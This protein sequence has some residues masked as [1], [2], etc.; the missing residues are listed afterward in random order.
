MAPATPSSSKPVHCTDLVDASESCWGGKK[1]PIPLT[2]GLR[3]RPSW[4][5]SSVQQKKCYWCTSPIR[6]LF[7]KL[8]PPPCAV[9]LVCILIHERHCLCWYRL[10]W[11]SLWISC[12]SDYGWMFVVSCVALVGFQL[13][14][15]GF[16]RKEW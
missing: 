11:C 3:P 8:P 4:H 1:K 15:T 13:S 16:G 10:F 9:L 14:L 5:A 7:L 6:F 12:V 2:E